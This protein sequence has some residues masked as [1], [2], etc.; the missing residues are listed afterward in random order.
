M[1]KTIDDVE[2][3]IAQERLRECARLS[4]DCRLRRERSWIARAEPCLSP[5]LAAPHRFSEGELDLDVQV[6]PVALED[7]VLAH[8]RA[9]RTPLCACACNARA[10]TLRSLST[11]RANRCVRASSRRPD[12]RAA[13]GRLPRETQLRS[14]RSCSVRSAGSKRAFGCLQW[15]AESRTDPCRQPDRHDTLSTV[16]AGRKDAHGG[17]RDR[18]AEK[19]AA[20]SPHAAAHALAHELS[21]RRAHAHAARD[22]HHDGDVDVASPGLARLAFAA[23]SQVDPRVDARGDLRLRT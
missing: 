16:G 22:T 23:Q 1:P 7:L 9:A 2:I 12:A 6:V 19:A 14:S 4:E 13:R 8:L 17:Q 10:R 15:G 11:R 3:E 18:A 5:V 20:R 21:H